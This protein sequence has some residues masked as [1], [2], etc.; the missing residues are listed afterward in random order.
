MAELLV[1]RHG[2]A[3]FGADDYDALSQVGHEQARLVGETLRAAGWVPDRLITGSLRRQQDT[4]T[5]MGLD[6]RREEHPGF[7]EYDFHD[8]LAVRFDGKVPGSV[9][10]D[11]RTHFRTLRDTILS[12]A[13]AEV[14]CTHVHAASF[15]HPHHTVLL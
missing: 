9:K 3:S 13:A 11:R 7:N 15:D 10:R 2:Q 5:A 4:L 12:H 6:G 14:T 1:I 8:L